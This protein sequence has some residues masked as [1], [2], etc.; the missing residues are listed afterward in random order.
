MFCLSD[1]M[2]PW[3]LHG[4]RGSVGPVTPAVCEQDSVL[5]TALPEANSTEQQ[6]KDLDVNFLRREIS[7]VFHWLLII[8]ALLPAQ[9][10]VS[11]HWQLS[12]IKLWCQHCYQGQQSVAGVEGTAMGTAG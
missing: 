3:A 8:N 7:D 11:M 6:F 10:F 5:D 1:P 12:M 2:A 4:Q 9:G